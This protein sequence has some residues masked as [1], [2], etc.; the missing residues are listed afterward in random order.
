[1]KYY[2]AC[3]KNKDP[4]AIVARAIMK[5]ENL[6]FNHVEII[7]EYDEFCSIYFGAVHPV[8]RWASESL[9]KQKYEIIEKIPLKI[10]LPEEEAFKFLM[11]L[12]GKPYSQMQLIIIYMKIHFN[13]IFGW[14]PYVKLN[15]DAALICT[16][17]AGIFMQKVCEYKID[18][19]TETLR[20]K[21]VVDIA[22]KALIDSQ[23]LK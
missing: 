19:S 6:P 11:S 17:L 7:A 1:M 23:T 22:K 5:E 8:S 2:L 20:L 10:T 15:L 3:L 12:I 21:E 4:N 18:I 13:K 14:L 9:I 16:E